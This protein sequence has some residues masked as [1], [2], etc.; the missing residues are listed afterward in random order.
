[1]ASN[2][3]AY[4]AASTDTESVITFTTGQ[5]G[6]N[7]TITADGTV[8]IA[9]AS[10]SACIYT[11]TS[12]TSGIL[13]F[14]GLNLVA[15]GTTYDLQVK[16]LGTIVFN[17]S[18]AAGNINGQGTIG[19]SSMTGNIIL[20]QSST[21]GPTVTFNNYT[22]QN[23]SSVSN[24]TISIYGYVNFIWNGGTLKLGP[25][26][27]IHVGTTITGC[28]FTVQNAVIDS[29]AITSSSYYMWYGG[30]FSLGAVTF[31]GN[32][33]AFGEGQG[34]G[35]DRGASSVTIQNNTLT[36][37]ASTVRTAIAV[38][39]D[40]P[41]ADAPAIP[42]ATISGNK[43][44][45]NGSGHSH[46]LLMGIGLTSGNAYDN[47]IIG[48]DYGIVVKSTGV[49]VHHNIAI[50]PQSGGLGGL[51]VRQAQTNT[52]LNN[53]FYVTAGP[54]VTFDHEVGS[55][56]PPSGNITE[57][58]I[59][60]QPVSNTTTVLSDSEGSTNGNMI[61]NQFDYNVYYAPGATF[62]AS[63]NC[64]ATPPTTAA[65]ISALR[66]AWA[67]YS[68]SY[69]TNDAHSVASDP[70]FT[71]KSGTYSLATDFT[72]AYNSPAIKAGTN[73]GLTTDYRG[74]PVPATPDIGAM[75]HLYSVGRV[76]SQWIGVYDP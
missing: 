37:T 48:A 59:F 60:Y 66:T 39:T 45:F 41:T 14:N 61:G 50:G 65:N 76:G 71:N 44:Y 38:G 19:N 30:V 10:G 16:G 26:N 25:S 28:N 3:V 29:T 34:I 40:G 5:S 9:P 74:R 8:N 21:P 53:T 55:A 72:L 13:T 4:V 46:G 49:S 57:N 54:S 70:K 69:P 24:E 67:T 64:G 23:G 18:G 63:L 62:F 6:K 73:V 20:F 36:T 33:V 31:S 7:L 75:Q 1:M 35:I 17:G 42:T 56:G 43:I 32:T 22:L 51:Y 15:T 68:S 11:T 47:L 2:D 58:N 12:F 52:I 27:G